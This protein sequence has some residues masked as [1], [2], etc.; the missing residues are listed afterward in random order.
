MLICLHVA[1]ENLAARRAYEAAGMA[2]VGSCRL[3]LPGHH[4][5]IDAILRCRTPEAGDIQWYCAGCDLSLRHP[6]SCGHRS[7]PHCQ[8]HESQQ[9]LERQLEKQ[10]PAQY[11][12]LTFTLPAEFRALAEVLS[13][14]LG[15]AQPDP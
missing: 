7:C 10:V 6:C 4:R 13:D 11:F 3:L 12:L 9:W 8:N 15:N 1:A 2:A 5:A 14:A